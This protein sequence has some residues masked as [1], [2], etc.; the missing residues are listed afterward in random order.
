MNKFI[1]SKLHA[2]EYI[3]DRV[4]NWKQD[5][6]NS[7]LSKD[8]FGETSWNN[9]HNHEYEVD[10]SGKGST[11]SLIPKDFDKPHDHT[12]T[13]WKVS[14]GPDGHIH[15]VEEGNKGYDLQK[16]SIKEGMY[17]T[18][19]MNKPDRTVPVYKN[20]EIVG[21]VNKNTT[22]IGAAKV[23]NSPS[24]YFGKVDGKYAWI[25]KS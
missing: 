1:E 7:D 16:E 20:N 4:Q 25:A 18:N 8:M 2:R 17:T 24:C 3:D 22:S 10:L 14:A 6:G 13:D 23:A 11:K 12:I 19:V 9:E 5:G 21:Y 15:F